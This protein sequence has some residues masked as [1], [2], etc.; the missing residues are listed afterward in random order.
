MWYTIGMRVRGHK[1]QTTTEA[2]TMKKF[3]GQNIESETTCAD[4]PYKFRQLSNGQIY[5]CVI[6]RGIWREITQIEYVG[7]RMAFKFEQVA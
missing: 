6:G 3:H 1:T 2:K 7:L 4:R 5:M